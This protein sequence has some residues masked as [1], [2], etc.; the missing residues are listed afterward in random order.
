VQ[1]VPQKLKIFAWRTCVNGLP[2]MRNLSHRGIHCSSFC[3]LCDRAI[4]ST[5]HALL[6]CDHAKLTWAQWHNCPIE[7]TSSSQEPVDIALDIIEKGSPN[8]L[9]LFFAMAWSIWWNRNQ[10][11]HEDSGSPPSQIWEMA[12]RILGECKDACSLPTLSLAPT[13]TIWKASPSGFFKINVN[14]T[15][16]DDGRPSRIGV[17]IRDCQGSPIA[18]SSRTLPAAF[19]AEITEAMALQE[20]VLLAAEMGISRAIFETDA[21]S[22]IQ[23]T[24]EGDLGGELGH[25]IQNIKDISSSFSWCTFQH[26]KR[27]GNRATHELAKAARIS[28]VSQVWKGVS[29][30]FVEHVILE[31][32]GM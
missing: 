23:A 11:L 29:P 6:L 15:A 5:A 31:E 32:R 22:T 13:P 14:G 2:T 18:A 3:P 10:A 7:V 28:G 26:L 4:E 16:L 19:S 30:S 12:N 24:N 20:G 17:I 9:E 21:L 25:I 8:D 1:K 27:S